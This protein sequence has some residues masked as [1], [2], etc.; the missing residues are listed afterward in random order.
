MEDLHRRLN[1]RGD[2][3]WR[4]FGLTVAL[5]FAGTFAWAQPEVAASAPTP[6]P[7]DGDFT[8]NPVSLA[9]VP[10]ITWFS[11]F[12]GVPWWRALLCLSPAP[13][14]ATCTCCGSSRSFG[15]R[16]VDPVRGQSSLARR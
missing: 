9:I 6:S 11:F 1:K 13:P 16:S 10:F 14:H 12:A 15:D 4:V 7:S 2:V 3:R 5:L 8:N